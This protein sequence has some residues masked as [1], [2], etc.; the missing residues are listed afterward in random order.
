MSVFL[1]ESWTEEDQR[2][3]AAQL[4]GFLLPFAIVEGYG[5]YGRGQVVVGD[6]KDKHTFTAIV[7]DGDMVE[8]GI[9]FDFLPH[10]RCSCGTKGSCSHMAAAI[11]W[12]LRQEGLD[13]RRFV[14]AYGL[15][16]TSSPAKAAAARSFFGSPMPA[17]RAGKSDA[18]G[19]KPGPVETPAP[20][21]GFRKWHR[22]FEQLLPVYRGEK[23]HFLQT[24]DRHLLRY[25]EDWPDMQ[26]KALYRMHA[27]LYA[28]RLADRTFALSAYGFYGIRELSDELIVLFAEELRGTDREGMTMREDCLAYARGLSVMIDEY[29]L[30][31]RQS[32]IRW[33]FIF[34]LVWTNIPFE[35]EL[36]RRERERLAESANEPGLDGELRML[37]I[38]A[39]AHLVVL[40]E[41][42][43][44]AL[45]FLDGHTET[46]MAMVY[47]FYDYLELYTE[48][49]QWSRL[50]LWLAWL[51]P[52][53]AYDR[54]EGMG[55]R[56]YLD[57]WRKLAEAEAT[58]ERRKDML[59]AMSEAL[60]YSFDLYAEALIEM[61]DYRRWADLHIALREAPNESSHYSKVEAKAPQVL[62]PV[63]HQSVERW[64]RGKNRDSYREAVRGMRQLE[65]LYRKA[66]MPERWREY[67]GQLLERYSRM[68]ALHEEMRKGGVI[69]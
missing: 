31:E 39:A 66:K 47:L 42:D 68:R 18:S 2:K 7:M 65:K 32:L 62:L 6:W 51:R 60:P 50:H 30:S 33:L 59:E 61:E 26:L 46:E 56:Y 48:T 63:F 16:G 53:M 35:P 13:V 8:T 69:R 1:K 40:E 21:G 38:A 28:M 20:G 5:I 4:R 57:C 45:A 27:L 10:S 23:E 14:K 34:R 43:A 11:F 52:R 64:I 55:S 41:N 3:M 67:T 15:E 25:A 44:A 9:R 36:R 17:G 19:A 37:R 49:R 24:V 54:N 22:Q 58:D 29:G 12:K